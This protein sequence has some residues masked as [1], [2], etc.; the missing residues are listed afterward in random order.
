MIAL[1]AVLLF[2]T[3]GSARAAHQRVS[4]GT[5]QSSASPHHGRQ[6]D[7]AAPSIHDQQSHLLDLASTPP[8]SSSA[9]DDVRAEAT[10]VSP[11]SQ[12]PAESV[13]AVGRAPPAL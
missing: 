13:T 5:G 8:A 7:T 11:D 12:L 10:V 4:A 1:V 9:P 6:V 2:A 3:G